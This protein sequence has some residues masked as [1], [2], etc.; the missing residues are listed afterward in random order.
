MAYPINL[1]E[2]I[3]TKEI[4]S[5]LYTLSCPFK[6]LGL[7]DIGARSTII[8]ANFT[9][10]PGTIVIAPLPYTE[11]SEKVIGGLPVKYLVGPNIVHHMAL[12]EWHDKFPESK[13]I[14]C[15]KLAAK[16][17]SDDVA[18]EVIVKQNNVLLTPKDI[19]IDDIDD[20]EDLKFI[21]LTGHNNRELVT[22]HGRTKSL[23][24]ADL[25]FNFPPIE[26]YSLS[27][28][29]AFNNALYKIGLQKYLPRITRFLIKD[30]NQSKTALK[31]IANL[32]F[33]IVIV[34]HGETITEN[35]NQ[36]FRAQFG[37]LLD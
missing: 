23:V 22:F 37:P 5:D 14:G 9:D 8:K 32:D 7:L 4:V 3:V 30:D 20:Q 24:V 11:S 2:T 10:G 1:D 28:S 18:I 19:G 17:A 16:K 12:K 13:V 15:E 25:A 27:P 36:W 29:T 21:L 34:C 35:G 33:D 31:S 26:Q 6:Q